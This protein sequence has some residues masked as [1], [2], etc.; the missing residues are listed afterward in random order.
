MIYK[1]VRY[2]DKVEDRI[3]GRLSRYPIIYTFIGGI[4]IVMFWRGVWISADQLSLILPPQYAWLDGPI[5]IVAS[6]FI[7]LITGLFVSFFV[8]D[9]IILSGLKQEKK[10]VE[11]TEN[12]LREETDLLAK[13]NT[14]MDHIEQDMKQIHDKL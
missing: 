1:V 11:K 3:R 2:L 4:G 7:L 9:R 14:K 13:L 6:M 10:L 8:T 5:S 12:E